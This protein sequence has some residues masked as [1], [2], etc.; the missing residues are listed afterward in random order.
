MGLKNK[1]VPLDKML[2]PDMAKAIDMLAYAFL[3]QQGYDTNRC[4]QKD[5][6]GS[7]ARTRLRKQLNVNGVELIQHMPTKENKIYCFF[8]LEDIKTEAKIAT[9]RTIEFV[10][11]I[12]EI[13]EDGKPIE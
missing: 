4:E 12:I 11:P 10:C 5:R 6:K 3:K 1:E 7:A 13:G 9:S 2:T 8:T